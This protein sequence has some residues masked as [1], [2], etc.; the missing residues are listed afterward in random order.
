MSII[1]NI[2]GFPSSLLPESFRQLSNG[3]KLFTI[4]ALAGTTFALYHA[5]TRLSDR[6]EDLQSKADEDARQKNKLLIEQKKLEDQLKELL[7]ANNNLIE[8]INQL[9][10]GSQPLEQPVKQPP[11]PLSLKAK[12]AGVS[13]E[14]FN[15]RVEAIK[16]ALS[17]EK[18]ELY[19]TDEKVR[20]ALIGGIRQLFKLITEKG[21]GT[22]GAPWPASN[23]SPS[24]KQKGFEKVLTNLDKAIVG[25]KG[26]IPETGGGLFFAAIDEALGE[27]L[28]TLF[29]LIEGGVEPKA[30]VEKGLTWHKMLP[31]LPSEE[32]DA[33]LKEL[34]KTLGPQAALWMI[35]DAI[36]LGIQS[37][38]NKLKEN[39]QKV[40]FKE[41][42]QSPLFTLAE[43]IID[44]RVELSKTVVGL[45]YENDNTQLGKTLWGG[46]GKILKDLDNQE[47]IHNLLTD[48]VQSIKLNHSTLLVQGHSALQKSHR[49][50]FQSKEEVTL[51]GV[52][53]LFNKSLTECL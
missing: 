44:L 1:R 5:Y 46:I 14:D 47:H 3:Q 42:P 23:D 9:Q 2:L 32:T 7:Q 11:P 15:K 22:G 13:D 34:V 25:V 51:H 20:Q 12:Y 49:Q 48:V 30:L 28:P 41:N 17:K 27:T 31:H 33:L 6:L 38:G 37:Q 29:Q 40:S 18:L 53:T 4:T 52:L 8:R 10:Q 16:G 43:V 45:L 26:A 24:K 39:I 21:A 36:Q 35:R 19:A 50:L